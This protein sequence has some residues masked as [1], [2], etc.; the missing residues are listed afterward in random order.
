MTTNSKEYMK[1]Y[2]K[3]YIINSPKITCDVCNGSYK[4]VY[5]YKHIKS[6][7]HNN[8]INFKNDFFILT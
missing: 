4:Q 3:S 6:K 8:I 7:I 5:K 2:F 1:K